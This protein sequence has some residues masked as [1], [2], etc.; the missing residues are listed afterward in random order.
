VVLGAIFA[1]FYSALMLAVYGD[2]MVR[3]EGADLAS[4]LAV[5]E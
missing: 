2:L 5:T 1:P 4:R 3:K